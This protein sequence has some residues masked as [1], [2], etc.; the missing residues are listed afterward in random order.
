MRSRLVDADALQRDGFY[1]P[2]RV[3]AA[4]KAA[5]YRQQVLEW[6]TVSARIGGDVRS[7]WNYPKVHLLA[8]WADEFV[9]EE[10][11]IDLAE[12]VIGPD[13]M[14][15]SINIFKRAAGSGEDLAWHQD[16][17]Y[18]GWTGMIGKTV[19]IW[20]ALTQTIPENGTMRFAR[21][22]HGELVAHAFRSNSPEDIMRGESVL[23]EVEEDTAVDVRLSPGEASMHLPT[24]V[25]CSTVNESDSDR[26]CVAVDF[27]SPELFPSGEDSALLVRG[28]D[29][30]GRFIHEPRLRVPYSPAALGEFRKACQRRDRMIIGEYRKRARTDG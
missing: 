10:S 6:E 13:L 23:V 8:G 4:D 29:Q 3:F 24:T 11:L 21:G 16:A 19:R 12:A 26:L 20:V 17:P 25:H 7:R 15:W 14:V 5:A 18:F 22:M 1:F 9:H 30:F 28:Q 27:I 2:V